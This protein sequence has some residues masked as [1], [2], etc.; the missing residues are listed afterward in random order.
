MRDPSRAGFQCFGIEPDARILIRSHSSTRLSLNTQVNGHSYELPKDITKK[1]FKALRVLVSNPGSGGL[2][3]E[4]LHGSAK[5]LWS[6]RVD[7]NYR[8]I[9]NWFK[10]GIP[11]V[12]Y[13]AKHDDAYD[14]SDAA[15]LPAMGD[16]LHLNAIPSPANMLLNL[17]PGVGVAKSIMSVGSSSREPSQSLSDIDQLEPLVSTRKYLPLA[18]E[19][20]NS[21][22][23]H[24]EFTFGQLEQIIQLPLP[25]SAKLYPAWWANEP[26]GKH[27]QAF[28]WMGIGW[29]VEKL[30]L[31][32]E[33]VMFRRQ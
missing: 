5:G 17:I 20:L 1:V 8:I 26:T 15:K 23:D 4:K 29:K 12:I 33:K 19:L 22:S 14:F 13:V 21:A 16:M 7:D 18:R 28:A 10:V 2:Q 6:A 30:G 9:F 31:K 24:A 11:V 3:I 25:E 27:V 32:N